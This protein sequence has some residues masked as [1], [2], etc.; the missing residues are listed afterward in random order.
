MAIRHMWR[1]ANGL[2]NADLKPLPLL[3]CNSDS[4]FTMKKIMQYFVQT[5]NYLY[6][7][8]NGAV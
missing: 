4:L 8:H 2:D 3:N 5:K 7:L 6:T 1:V